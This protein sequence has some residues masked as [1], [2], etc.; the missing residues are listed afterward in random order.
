QS[1]GYTPQEVKTHRDRL[2]RELNPDRLNVVHVAQSPVLPMPMEQLLPPLRTAIRRAIQRAPGEFAHLLTPWKVMHWQGD[3]PLLF[4]F[5]AANRCDGVCR[6]RRLSLPDGRVV[7]ICTEL[8]GNPG[9]SITNSLELIAFQ[10]CA[11]LQI[12]PANLVWIEHH[13]KPHP[14]DRRWY[15]VSFRSRPPRSMFRC[16]SWKLMT[17]ADWRSLGLPPR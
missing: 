3:D 14:E 10:V 8:P 9:E 7:V 13:G 15:L 6:I 17:P 11:Q 12:N 5:K 1:K 16:P 4:A 2:Y